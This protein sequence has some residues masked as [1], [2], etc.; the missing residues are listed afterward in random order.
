MSGNIKH[1][2]W[3][4]TGVMGKSMAKHL[5]EKGYTMSVFTR[6]KSKAEELINL[7]ASFKSPIEIAQECD[8]LFLMLGYPKDLRNVLFLE[9]GGIL[10]HLKTGSILVDHTT[11]APG[12]AIEIHDTA[13]L[14]GVSCI[15]A[16]VSGGDVGAKNGQLAIM[17][18]G[19]KET[20]EK[21]SLLINFVGISYLGS[22]WKKY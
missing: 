9:E 4:G 2:G 13:K 10:Q 6:T 19:D 7:G 3:I 21:V 12:L 11:S 14:R 15:D 18:G 1:I 5:I 22:L 20:F 8:A 16:P 17:C